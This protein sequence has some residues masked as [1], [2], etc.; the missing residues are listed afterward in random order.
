MLKRSL[1][2]LGI[3]ALQTAATEIS[4]IGNGEISAWPD[5]A[6]MRIETESLKPRLKDALTESKAIQTQA[7]AIARR[8]AVRDE[9]VEVAQ[10]S[11]NRETEWDGRTRRETFLG[12]SATQTIEVRIDSLE[13]LSEFV[14]EILKLKST[15]IA[16]VAFRT[17]REDSLRNEAVVRAVAGARRTGEA[18]AASQ[19]LKVTGIKEATNYLERKKPERWEVMHEQSPEISVYGK[20]IG[21]AGISFSPRRL[22][23][24]S[25][26]HVVLEAQ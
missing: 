6:E 14:D 23:Y 17:A 2:L 5:Y 11:T 10:T 20:G 13:R 19:G 3:F 18:I 7:I 12:F 16:A 26:A 21:A 8:F 15:R 9:L 22:V 1:S 4:T 25:S 24:S